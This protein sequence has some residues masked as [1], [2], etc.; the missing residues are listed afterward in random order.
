MHNTAL[1][2]VPLALGVVAVDV[3]VEVVLEVVVLSVVEG[4]D[5]VGT[6]RGLPRPE[7]K[8]NSQSLSAAFNK[9]GK[10][11]KRSFDF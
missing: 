1:P 11:T 4:E 9:R 5:V 10:S 7:L 2:G 3:L 8:K 6:P